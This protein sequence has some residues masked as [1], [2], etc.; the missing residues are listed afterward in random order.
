[1]RSVLLITATHVIVDNAP[2]PEHGLFGWNEPTWVAVG[3]IVSVVVAVATLAVALVTKELAAS[4]EADRKQAEEHHQ[5]ALSPFCV[6]REATSRVEGDAPQIIFKVQNIG[7]GSAVRVNVQMVPVKE[8]LERAGIGV[9]HFMGPLLPS[10]I[11]YEIKNG[12]SGWGGRNPFG[13]FVVRLE[14]EN[15]FGSWGVTEWTV[16]GVFFSHISLEPASVK[17]VPKIP[18]KKEDKP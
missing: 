10:E 1:M 13:A 12:F 7:A 8:G 18:A 2:Q 15:M 5:R 6:I 9:S 17:I 4:D 3:A 11:S 16:S 14:F